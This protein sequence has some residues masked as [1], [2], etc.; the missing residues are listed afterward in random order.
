MGAGSGRSDG[1]GFNAEQCGEPGEFQDPAHG[2]GRC[3]QRDPIGDVAVAVREQQ[4]TETAGV[5]ER[6]VPHVEHPDRGFVAHATMQLGCRCRVDLAVETQ[7]AIAGVVDFS[8]MRIPAWTTAFGQV[9]PRHVTP[10]PRPPGIG[11]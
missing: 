1:P 8:T 10:G 2:S 4:D 11:V 5:N 7:Y 9:R 6:D 3:L